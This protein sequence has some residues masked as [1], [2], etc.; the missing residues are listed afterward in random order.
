MTTKLLK[1]LALSPVAVTI[2]EHSSAASEIAVDP[3]A[4]FATPSSIQEGFAMFCAA[5]NMGSRDPDDF[6]GFTYTGISTADKLTG[7]TRGVEG[8]ARTWS[9]GTAVAHMAGNEH[10]ERIN[11]RIGEVAGQAPNSHNLVDTTN[12]PATGLTSGHFLKATGATTY[13]FGAHGLTNTDVG[14]S[15]VTNDKQLPIAG[16]TMTGNLGLKQYTETITTLGSTGTVSLNV[17]NG[18]VFYTAQGDG[19]V[20]YTFADPSTGVAH[21]LTLV[22]KMYSTAKS[23]VWPAGV[24]WPGGDIPDA[25]DVSKEAVYTFITVRRSTAAAIWHGLQAGIDF[26]VYST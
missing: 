18:S 24:L 23:V 17:A 22:H 4:S 13:A 25:P 6:E 14:L 21:S 20:T 26:E 7:V 15:N 2:G 5:A 16:G 19:T 12:H 8:T 9:E 3:I 10:F 11:A 1:T